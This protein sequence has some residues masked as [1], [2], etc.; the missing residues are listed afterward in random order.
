MKRTLGPL[1][2]LLIAVALTVTACGDDSKP[3]GFLGVQRG[4]NMS[5]TV[6]EV[7]LKDAVYYGETK[8][9]V[10]TYYKVRPSDPE[11]KLAVA[12]ITLRN[13]KSTRLVMNVDD[14][15][16]RLLDKAGAEYLSVDPFKNSELSPSVPN[17]EGLYTWVWGQFDIQKE[18]GVTGWALFEVP[19]DLKP[20]QL[21]WDTVETIFVRFEE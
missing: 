13:D 16:Y 15:S 12:S 5:L 8:D 4:N 14:K 9:G 2:T 21:R 11:K 20:T 3:K 18:F 6:Y 17:N 7:T 1:F 10:A 19:K